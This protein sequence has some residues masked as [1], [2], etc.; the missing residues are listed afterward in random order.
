MKKKIIYTDEPIQ[1]RKIKDF[2][3]SPEFFI[4]K[5]ES[6]KRVTIELSDKSLNFFKNAAQKQKASYQVMIRRLLDFYV[7]KQQSK[8]N[9]KIVA[10]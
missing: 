3:P 10:A 6:K 8:D 4:L 9:F 2:L 1:S 7:A 5:K